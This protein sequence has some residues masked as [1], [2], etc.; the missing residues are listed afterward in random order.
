M[1]FYC[2][3]CSYYHSIITEVILIIR[4]CNFRLIFPP[5]KFDKK[6]KV[7]LFIHNSFIL[8]D[9]LAQNF[10]LICWTVPLLL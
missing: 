9:A 10:K 8:E 3:Y 5:F 4:Y 6:K 2:A 7:K 1:L